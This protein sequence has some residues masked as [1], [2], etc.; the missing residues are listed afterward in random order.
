MQFSENISVHMFTDHEV[1]NQKLHSNVALEASQ[2]TSLS[3]SKI[4]KISRENVTSIADVPLIPQ[5]LPS[6]R[7]KNQKCECK[8]TVN[9]TLISQNHEKCTYC[10]AMKGGISVPTMY[11][12]V[13]PAGYKDKY[14]QLIEA[15]PDTGTTRTLFPQCIIEKFKWNKMVNVNHIERIE[16]ANDSLLKCNGQIDLEVQYM[17]RDICIDALVTEDISKPLISWFDLID[18][19]CDFTGFSFLHNFCYEYCF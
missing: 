12:A 2:L 8:S 10:Y 9:N 1:S 19:D 17:G 13:K 4:C 5:T 15:M 11:M 6:C 14:L 16:A 3:G 18:L 7:S